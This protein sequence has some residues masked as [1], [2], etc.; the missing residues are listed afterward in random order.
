MP[1]L[2]KIFGFSDTTTLIILRILVKMKLNHSKRHL[3][4]Q[5]IC[6]AFVCHVF[7][8]IKSKHSTW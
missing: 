7:D 4:F 3:Y 5:V 8:V 2:E 1:K 6:H